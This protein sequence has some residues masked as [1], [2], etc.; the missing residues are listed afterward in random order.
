MIRIAVATLFAGSIGVPAL[1]QENA[2][3]KGALESL[4]QADKAIK[5]VNSLD[6]SCNCTVADSLNEIPFET[7]TQCGPDRNYLAKSTQN[8]K[9]LD[10]NGSYWKTRKPPL[11]ENSVPGKCLLYLMRT[12]LRDRPRSAEEKKAEEWANYEKD[13]KDTAELKDKVYK[14]DPQQFAACP[15][16]SGEPKRVGGK[17]CVT[18]DYFN[19]IF[20]SLRDVSDCLDIPMNFTV[21]KFANESGF[22]VNAFGPVND[23]G[24]GQFTES[25]LLDVA[26]N[27]PEFRPKIE[28]SPKDSCKRLRSFPGALVQTPEEILAP[29]ANRCHA[30]GMPPNPLRSL[31]YYGV[32]YKATLRN[33]EKAWTR[34]DDA[35]ESV[36]SLMAEIGAQDFDKT[37]IKQMLFTLSYNMGPRPPVAAMKEWLRY[38]LNRKA[39]LRKKDFDFNFWPPK[40]FG[41][42]EKEL[43]ETLAQKA[44]E[45]GWTEEELKLEFQKEKAKKKIAHLGAEKRSL[46]FPEY[47]YV[48]RNNIY[49]SAVKAQAN[50]LAKTFGEGVCAPD[51]FL[52]L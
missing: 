26:Q 37:T 39:P 11:F 7:E 50:T 24:I 23:G 5:A 1:A 36:D 18:P 44:Q 31:L 9:K 10:P 21:P 46:T 8:F 49:I 28:N 22:H 42:I 19:I 13:G 32:F 16:A 35:N 4:F 2:T 27:F 14:P 48:Y 25:A 29:D 40:G 34:T 3:L 33:A 43:Q 41:A 47:L 17:P 30:I 6:T 38:R 20:N 12:S 15:D 51:N 52:A 45:E